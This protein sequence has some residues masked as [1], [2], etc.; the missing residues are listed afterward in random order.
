MGLLLSVIEQNLETSGSHLRDVTLQ[1]TLSWKSSQM[2]WQQV[3][4]CTSPWQPLWVLSR[5]WLLASSPSCRK[6]PYLIQPTSTDTN[7][8][9][10]WLASQLKINLVKLRPGCT[11]LT[12]HYLKLIGVDKRL[13][14]I[15]RKHWGS[16]SIW[17]IF[18]TL[19]LLEAALLITYSNLT[20]LEYY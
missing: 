20:K 1:V 11:S 10:L 7:L 15:P 12:L 4:G 14:K 5:W 19:P 9:C 6:M 8:S 13:C 17:A 16:L 2:Q 18:G 3:P